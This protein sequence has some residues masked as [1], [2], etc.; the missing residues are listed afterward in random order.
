MKKEEF[1]ALLTSEGYQEI[2]TVMREG[3]QAM[4]PH[5]H[6]FEAKALVLA[7]EIWISSEQQDRCYRPGDRFHLAADEEHSERYGAQGVTYVVG[8]KGG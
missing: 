8:R 7:G 3:G 4:E 6:P 5:R 2:V 1:E